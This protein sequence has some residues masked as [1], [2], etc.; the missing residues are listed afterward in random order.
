MG[1]MLRFDRALYREM[2]FIKGLKRIK[3]N[4]QPEILSLFSQPVCTVGI[5]FSIL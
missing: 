1:M 3:T 2:S 5:F 4:V